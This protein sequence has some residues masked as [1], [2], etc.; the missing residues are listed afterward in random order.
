MQETSSPEIIYH[1]HDGIENFHG[2]QP[3]G[4]H[5][6]SICDAYSNG[7]YRII[8]KLGFGSYSTVWL[9]RDSHLERYVALKILVADSSKDSNEARILTHITHS[10]EKN[11]RTGKAFILPIFD[12]FQ[13]DGPNG[14]HR[15][16]T[17]EPAGCSLAKSKKN[18][19]WKFR[20]QVARAIAA[21]A[22]LGLR[23]IHGCNVVHGGKLRLSFCLPYAD[24]L[25]DLHPNNIL[26]ALRDI[27]HMSVDDIYHH[28]STPQRTE[29]QRLD[30]GPLSP[31]V[32]SH[33]TF[34]A[35][36]YVKCLKVEDPRIRI[37]DFGESWFGDAVPPKYLNTPMLYRPP[38]DVFAKGLLG[39]P[40]DIWTLA[41]SV[42][43]I[44]GD[45]SLFEGFCPS[46]ADLVSEMVSCLGPLP[47]SWWDA[48]EG[49]SKF[50]VENGVWRTD[51][52]L[53][54]RP[55]R[56]RI[57]IMDRQEHPDF[58]ADEA[59]SLAVM[60]STMLEYDP[61]KRAS[62]TDVVDSDWMTRWGLPSLKPFNISV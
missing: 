21:Q 46:E 60:L 50:F 26:F 29:V 1:W 49:R 56:S 32:P 16:L 9:A 28:F 31:G 5:P 45:R 57:Q 22:I 61:A 20:I 41:C 54:S 48:W 44:M 14:Q 27:H 7:R 11:N 42:F 3:G 24:Y 35:L 47:P 55:L 6:A 33:A 8:H 62:A 51:V 36:L 30:G 39:F 58:F 25:H 23:A 15:C 34:P 12:D 18:Q 53:R 19:P 37:T 40:S 43:E 17:T 4:Y 59:E 38:E 52:G 10:S 13:I 2:Y